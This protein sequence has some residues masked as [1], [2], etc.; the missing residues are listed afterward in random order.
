MS[1]GGL[2]GGL[3]GGGQDV[4]TSGYDRM[5][6]EAQQR[7]KEAEEQAKKSQDEQRMAQDEIAANNRNKRANAASR[8]SLLLFED[9]D[10]LGD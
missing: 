3:L 10:L 7:A 6:A 1:S 2:L 4:D 9:N 8:F 5:V